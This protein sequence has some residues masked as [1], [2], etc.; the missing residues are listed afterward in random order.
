MPPTTDSFM[1]RTMHRQPD[2]LR[3]LVEN[4]WDQAS[5]GASIIAPATGDVAAAADRFPWVASV[6]ISRD[7]PRGMAVRVTEATPAAVA[8]FSDQAVLVS[9]AG[10]GAGP[11]EGS[12]GGGGVPPGR[13]PL[14]QPC[15]RR[16]PARPAAA[17]RSRPSAPTTWPPGGPTGPRTSP[18]RCAWPAPGRWTRRGGTSSPGRDARRSSRGASTTPSSPRWVSCAPRAGNLAMKCC[19][20]ALRK[21]K[22]TGWV[23]RTADGWL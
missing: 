8:S 22:I 13:R 3:N 4:G 20:R 14:V 2:D 21:A 10:R 23:D 16:P 11:R 15:G 17:T 12:P 7:W 1:Y 18:P 9:A 5:E 19:G 6:S